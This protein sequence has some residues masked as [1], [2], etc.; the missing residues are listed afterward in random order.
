MDQITDLGLSKLDE[1]MLEKI[2]T[3]SKVDVNFN[4]SRKSASSS[5]SKQGEF[6]F[7]MLYLPDKS[8]IIKV[9]WVNH[10]N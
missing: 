6:N 4:G 2:R 5:N 3:E 10:S 7:R 1:E 9:Q 8:S